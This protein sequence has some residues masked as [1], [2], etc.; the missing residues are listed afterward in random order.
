MCK[1]S[2]QVSKQTNKTKQRKLNKQAN[3]KAK[4]KQ[5]AVLVRS[6]KSQIQNL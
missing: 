3:E 5:L 4:L 2:C 6:E 1:G